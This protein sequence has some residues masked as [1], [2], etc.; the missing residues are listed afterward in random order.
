MSKTIKHIDLINLIFNQEYSDL[1]K[2]IKRGEYIYELEYNDYRCDYVHDGCEY[3]LEFVDISNPDDLGAEV[4]IIEEHKI[5]KLDEEVAWDE[6]S[7]FTQGGMN[8]TRQEKVL[9]KKINEI[10]DELGKTE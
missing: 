7:E 1:P 6:F 8:W 3:L 9:V 2:K 4:E 5:E 10:I